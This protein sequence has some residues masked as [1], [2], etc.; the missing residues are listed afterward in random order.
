MNIEIVDDQTLL[1]F[2]RVVAFALFEESHKGFPE[3]DSRLGFV[4][5]IGCEG[6][7]GV[8]QAALETGKV[9]IVAIPAVRGG[10]R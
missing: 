5:A 6:V 8:V 2:F 4:D 10:N 1:G 3:R 7:P 9:S